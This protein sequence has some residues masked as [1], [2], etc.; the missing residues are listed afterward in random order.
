MGKTLELNISAININSFNM[1]TYGGANNNKTFVKIEGI[2]SK[3]ND[4][5]HISDCR[6]GKRVKEVHRKDFLSLN[7][8]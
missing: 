5:I 3:K 6:L 1:S 7:K 2:T 4:I 8:R